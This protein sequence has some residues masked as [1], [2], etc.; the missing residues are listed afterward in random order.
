MATIAGNK[1]NFN[2]LLYK[3]QRNA[4]MNDDIKRAARIPL[5]LSYKGESPVDK[6]MNC[7]AAQ[8]NGKHGD[9]KYKPDT[10]KHSR[11]YYGY[12]ARIDPTILNAVR[13]RYVDV[14]GLL[15]PN[16]ALSKR[17]KDT[18]NMTQHPLQPYGR[19]I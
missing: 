5:D 4:D 2:N 13:N 11:P 14:S 6:I 8:I 18:I 10:E 16:Y 1:G 19:I 15:I 12:D 9:L 17:G 3:T 7:G